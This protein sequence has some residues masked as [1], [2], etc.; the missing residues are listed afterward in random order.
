MRYFLWFLFVFVTA[1]MDAAVPLASPSILF[2]RAIE[3]A[4]D[5]SEIGF[6]V[7]PLPG[8][9]ALI[10]GST[11]PQNGPPDGLL[12]RVNREGKVLWRKVLGGTG[13][14]LI[15]SCLPDGP[16]EFVCV[17]FK[18]PSGEPTMKAMDGWILRINSKGD[19][20]WE[21]TY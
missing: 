15:F 20:L 14:D 1:S 12:I 19:L 2:T 13:L 17:G 8:D 10:S 7:L 5:R 18:A 9:E 3:A 11:A 21:H 4:G 6:D 16:D